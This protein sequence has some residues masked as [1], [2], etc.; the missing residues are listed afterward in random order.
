MTTLHIW[1]SAG[2]VTQIITMKRLKFNYQLIIRKI[3]GCYS[4]LSLLVSVLLSK[5]LC[6]GHIIE[7]YL[8]NFACNRRKNFEKK[9]FRYGSEMER[10]IICQ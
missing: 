6:G 2:H 3:H 7:S 8:C 10:F 4:S 9:E 5:V 1:A